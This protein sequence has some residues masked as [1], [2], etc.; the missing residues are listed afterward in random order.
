MY[1]LFYFFLGIVTLP[2][3]AFL[4]SFVIFVITLTIDTIKSW[5][6]SDEDENN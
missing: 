6:W 3:L 5:K 4:I 1:N 2:F